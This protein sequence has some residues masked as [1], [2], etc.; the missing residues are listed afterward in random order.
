MRAKIDGNQFGLTGRELEIIEGLKRG[1]RCKEIAGEIGISRFTVHTHKRN[2]FEKTG[3]RTVGEVIDKLRGGKDPQCIDLVASF[4][5]AFGQHVPL[6][7]SMPDESVQRLRAKLC[8]EESNEL[9]EAENLVQ[10]VDAICDLLYVALGSAVACGLNSDTLER[11]FG[12]VHRSNMS[13]F[14]KAEELK[15]VPS[16]CKAS[17]CTAGYI[18]LRP[19]GKVLKSPSYSPANLA[20]LLEVKP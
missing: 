20:P 5:L 12:E 1:L 9:G 4:M 13:K 19:D 14:W 6:S 18:V 2:I 7:V 3:G 17:K 10:Y 11:C 8:V 16:G 15:S